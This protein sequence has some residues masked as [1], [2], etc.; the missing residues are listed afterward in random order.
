MK[1]TADQLVS[2]NSPPLT[3]RVEGF[4]L[5]ELPLDLLEEIA[6]Y[7][8]RPEAAA[9]VTVSKSFHTAFARTVWKYIDLSAKKHRPKSKSAWERY[10]HLVHSIR[11]TSDVV[12]RFPPFPPPNLNRL[13]VNLNDKTCAMLPKHELPHLQRLSLIVLWHSCELKSFIDLVSWI[14]KAHQRKQK[15]M[16]RWQFTIDYDDLSFK[17]L[18][19]VLAHIAMLDSHEFYISSDCPRHRKPSKMSK[20][21]PILKH[22]EI[23]NSSYGSSFEKTGWFLL[24]DQELI[25]PRVE[26]LTISFCGGD[27]EKIDSD[28][29][30]DE[31]EDEDTDEYRHIRASFSILSGN[32]PML[33]R[34]V[35]EINYFTCSDD[36]QR[37]FTQKW[38]TVI[39]L[40][41]HNVK[42][43]LGNI[44]DPSV[45]KYAVRACPSLE[46]LTFA[47]SEFTLD[48]NELAELSPRLRRLS[49]LN[50]DETNDYPPPQQHKSTLQKQQIKHLLKPKSHQIL[51]SLVHVDL[52]HSELDTGMLQLAIC[53]A[54]NL[55]TIV[56]G[57][58]STFKIDKS[59]L[60]LFA[61]QKSTSVQRLVFGMNGASK[62]NVKDA[63]AFIGMFPNLESLAAPKEC[64]AKLKSIRKK[65]PKL[66]IRE[67]NQSK[68]DE[69]L[70]KWFYLQFDVGGHK[71]IHYT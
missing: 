37:I 26:S 34:F 11:I 4:P 24:P 64:L 10:S 14:N 71:N 19:Y 16:V 61:G 44:E 45:W 31:N 42:L 51:N 66:V 57:I 35:M 70:Y 55:K 43:N 33:T 53:L 12:A 7:F 60:E 3:D 25:F 41:I 50:V 20:L 6:T 36:A 13:T 65:Y 18:D 58:E 68:A 52:C 47:G 48:L 67:Y 30:I 21:V 46:R 22:I 15:L 54:P 38:P 17:S 9:I 40:V 8:A 49:V 32:F 39:E 27:E 5:V 63:I 1:R 59:A 2:G 56:A 28:Y 69:E 62:F 23:N 29:D